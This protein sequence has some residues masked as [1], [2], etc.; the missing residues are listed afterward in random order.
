MTGVQTCALPISVSL[1][2]TVIFGQQIL[3]SGHGVGNFGSNFA[4]ALNVTTIIPGPLFDQDPVRIV[5]VTPT[6]VLYKNRL[7]NSQTLIRGVLNINENTPQ[8]G[9]MWFNSSYG[10][11]SSPIQVGN[12][13]SNWTQIAFGGVTSASY[14]V[15]A[16]QNIAGIF[17][18]WGVNS[19][20]QLG[21]GFTITQT[22][23]AYPVS[24]IG[25]AKLTGGAYHTMA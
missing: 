14:T 21:N 25:W 3:P 17:M 24:S 5:G 10:T 22:T 7:N 20:G 9:G 13:L 12:N 16:S 11:V 6:S 4:G 15:Y 2:R 18:S 8:I 19:Y 1:R 23:P